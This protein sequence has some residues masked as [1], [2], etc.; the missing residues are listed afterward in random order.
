[1]VVAVLVVTAGGIYGA[2]ALADHGEHQQ[3]GPAAAPSPQTTRVKRADLSDSRTL[4][5]VLGFGGQVTVKGPGKGIISRLPDPGSVVSRGKPLYWVD[6]EPVIAFFGDTPF[7]RAL[8]KEGTT[9]RDVTVLVENLQAL[10]YDIDPR[11][12][13]S[14]ASREGSEAGDAGTE[15]TTGVMAALK[16]WQHDTGQE[17]TGTLAPDRAV[18]LSGPSRVDAVKAQLGDP[19]VEE[20]LT[21]TSQ[22]KTVTVEADA[23]S[24]G[25]IHQGDEVSIILPDTRSVPGK[26]GS[27]GTTVQGG[28]TVEAGAGTDT[29]PTLEVKV[30]PADADDVAKLDAASVQVVFT[31]RTR[32]NVLVVPVGALLALSEGGY[33]LQRPGGKLV[34]VKTG[35]FAKGLVEVSGAGIEEGDVV[36]TAS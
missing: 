8:D 10:G 30:Q 4:P 28:D 2:R 3:P 9:G 31:A 11:P 25:S 16:R 21:L 27:I 5:G 12:Q 26:V 32:E 19:A 6:D 14:A 17:T 1:M 22:E 29:T 20:V 18:V 23:G 35:L 34:G 15:L 24:A 7:F 36:V 33:A 13:R